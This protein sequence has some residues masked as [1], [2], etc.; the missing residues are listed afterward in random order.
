MYSES[1]TGNWCLNII[2]HP[3][4]VT[5]YSEILEKFNLDNREF[6]TE[7]INKY[8]QVYPN[9]YNREDLEDT[10]EQLS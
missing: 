1:F 9:N 5:N 6:Q 3:I 7:V 2:D 8:L 10:A 4:A